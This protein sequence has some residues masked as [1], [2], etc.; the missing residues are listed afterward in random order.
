[1]AAS[2]VHLRTIC[3][4]LLKNITKTISNQNVILTSLK[5]PK[6]INHYKR[7]I[8]PNLSISRFL[9]L[10]V[11]GIKTINKTSK[12]ADSENLEND[13]PQI[14]LQSNVKKHVVADAPYPYIA[15]KKF[16][17]SKH[18]NRDDPRL[19]S[20]ECL[21]NAV[22]MAVDGTSAVLSQTV[23]QIIDVEK[24]YSE[25]MDALIALLEYQLTILGHPAEEERIA[26]IILEA[27]H[28]INEVQKKRQD[29]AILFSSAEKLADAT[30]EVA[31]ASGADYASISASERLNSALLEVK[32]YQ[33][34]SEEMEKKLHQ[35]Q[36]RAVH[37]MAKH[38]EKMEQKRQ[39]KKNREMSYDESEKNENETE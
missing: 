26:D 8:V 27:R 9:L 15:E 21:K 25:L 20:A 5:T 23:Y 16:K 36:A 35:T 2:F 18:Y 30:A 22:G 10:S 17:A 3:G 6:L 29:L 4:V 38:E 7:F 32:R 24:E 39:K 12:S 33:Q 1:M 34:K 11:P 31:F 13:P 14:D 28:E 37:V 19:D